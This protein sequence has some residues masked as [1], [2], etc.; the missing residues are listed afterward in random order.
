MY[1]AFG[2]YG[3]IIVSFKWNYMLAF[4]IL[5]AVPYAYYYLS[6]KDKYHTLSVR[7]SYLC[8]SLTL[9]AT[10]LVWG[11]SKSKHSMLD[12]H[13]KFIDSKLN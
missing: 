7:S 9:T 10:I 3:I 13:C 11:G 8:T 5:M 6:I 1:R 2:R 4:T 12:F